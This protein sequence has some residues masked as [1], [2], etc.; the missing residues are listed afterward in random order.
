MFALAESGI[1]S[2]IAYS[3]MCQYLN[4]PHFIDYLLINFYAANV[5]FYQNW[6]CDG[7]VTHGVPFHFFSWDAEQTFLSVT[8]DFPV[9]YDS[10]SVGVL[11][12]ALREHPDYRRLFGDHA[13]RLL[14]NRGALTPERCAARWMQR[15]Q[16]IDLAVIAESARWGVTNSTTGD[17]ITHTDWVQ[18][19]NF[20]L[21]NW[22][23]QR[24]EIFITQLR[25]AGLYP[26]VDAP[27][28]TPHA[29]IIAEPLAVTI[30]IPTNTVLY[31]TTN[32]TDPRLPDGTVSPS[33]LGYEDKSAV[34]LILTN[35]T[36]LCARA[37]DTN[38]WSSLVEASYVLANEVEIKVSHVSYESDGGVRLGFLAW[39][40]VS[41]TL[42]AATNLNS[43]PMVRASS[44]AS[45]PGWEVIATLVPFPDGTFSF[46]DAD[47]TNYPARFY[48]LTWP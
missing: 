1:T 3:E 8:N 10:W 5:D 9:F 41:Y 40:G 22:F 27:V 48:R 12:L 36:Q 14:F 20:L 46:V 11:D 23:P 45:S 29:G 35:D 21:T 6:W 42:L 44:G 16:E 47:A 7:S 37:L 13:Q 31:Y 38:T 18:E 28:F 30:T 17:P 34:M 15:A 25:N 26:G 39:P 4:V 43:A 24:T 32:G 33:A 2:E 19:Q